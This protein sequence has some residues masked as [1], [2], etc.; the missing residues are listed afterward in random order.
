M[1]SEHQCEH[2]QRVEELEQENAALKLELAKFRKPPKDSGN[3]GVPPSQDPYRKPYPTRSV[4]DKATGGQPGHKG[5][6]HPFVD[7]DVVEPVYPKFCQHCGGS[8]L[9]PLESYHQ[10]RQEVNLPVIK[11]VV[12]EYRQYEVLC[13]GCGERSRGQF[14]E[15][16]KAPVQMAESFSG[17]IGYLKQ[18]QHLSHQRIAHF[19]QDVLGFKVSQGFID[20]RLQALAGSFE[21]T[22]QQLAKALPEQSLLGSDETRQRINGK[23][24]YL[25]VFQNNSLCWFVGN[26]SRKFQVIETLFGKQ[27]SGVWVSDRFG[28]QL[29]IEAEHQL[30]LVHLIRNLQYAI[31]AE[32]SDWAKSLQ[33]LLKATIHFRKQQAKAFDPVHNQDVF[34]QCQLFQDQLA[35]LFQKPP[36]TAEARILF[37]SLVGRQHQLLLFLANPAVPHHNNASEQALRQPVVHRKVLGGFR[38]E[39]GAKAQDILLSVIETAKRQSL[40]VF[41][42]LC[43]RDALIFQS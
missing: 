33:S 36:P 16:L 31:D 34:R 2:R 6:H 20:N 22:Y 24:H 9:L 14:P 8:H 15:H 38:T 35:E 30:C 37:R 25:W 10:V 5:H 1:S 32:Q 7:P 40:N 39:Q 41:D 13:Q 12:T 43:K 11:P 19:F 42:V 18:V 21:T 3:S 23:N 26:A 4:S 29:K 28:S 17:L 27:F